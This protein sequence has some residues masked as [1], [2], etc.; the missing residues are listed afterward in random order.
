MTTQA[1]HA[2]VAEHGE[3]RCR[4]CGRIHDCYWV[5]P[6]D[7]AKGVSWADR[8]DGHPYAPELWRDVA[9]RYGFSH[10]VERATHP[11]R[12]PSPLKPR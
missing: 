6:G 11:P 3:V 1:K 5:D 4:R 9:I 7:E 12:V 10:S 2:R 8:I